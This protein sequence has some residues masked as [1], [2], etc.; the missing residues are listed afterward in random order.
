M[1]HQCRA[2]ALLAPFKQD[3]QDM[4]NTLDSERIKQIH[5]NRELFT[6]IVETIKLCGAENIPLR[7]HR[8]DVKLDNQ[9]PNVVAAENDGNFRHLLRYRVQGA[10]RCFKGL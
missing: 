8:D 4:R 3:R 6:S 1:N 7:G 2:A 10:I 5:Q 9:G